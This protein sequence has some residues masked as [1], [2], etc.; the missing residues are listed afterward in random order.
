MTKTRNREP[1]VFTITGDRAVVTGD[2]YIHREELKA[3]DFKWDFQAKHWHGPAA[4]VEPTRRILFA[5]GV[6]ATV[7]Q[8]GPI[9]M[10]AP[11][12]LTPTDRDPR[13]IVTISYDGFTLNLP[14]TPNQIEM[15]YRHVV[16]ASARQGSSV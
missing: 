7:I 5:A 4:A 14:A 10:L 6:N 16:G 15:L 2:A 9:P 3:Q 13:I 1:I 8:E 11:L 12:L